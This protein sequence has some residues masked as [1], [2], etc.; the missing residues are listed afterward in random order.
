MGHVYCNEISGPVIMDY[1]GLNGWYS[2]TSF[3]FT[4][5]DSCI[6][7]RSYIQGIDYRA[8]RTGS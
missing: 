1:Q 7:H 8:P 5:H 3:T 4:C 6:V 2:T